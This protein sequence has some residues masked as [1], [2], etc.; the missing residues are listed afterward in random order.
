MKAISEFTYQ[1][2]IAQ[3]LDYRTCR[4]ER[5]T[6]L[7]YLLA[8]R[9]NDKEQIA[10]FES[11][12]DSVHRIIHNVRTYERGLLFG[13]TSKELNGHGWLIGMLPI[14]ENIEL[15][16][17]NC[18]HIGQ[19]INGTYAVTVDWCTGSAGGGSHPSI[20]DKP[21]SSYK[22]AIRSGI[23]EL[24]KVYN[25]AECYSISDRGNYNPKV[26][27]KLKAKLLELKRRYTQPQQLSLF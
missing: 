13:Y 11:F 4:I 10:Y 16:S 3:I 2:K 7:P 20:W 14:I 22:E 18:I 24:E 5:E 9:R 23:H 6:K 21:I 1:E 25:K 12:G 26:I 17:G 8:I 27:S 15:E 19:S